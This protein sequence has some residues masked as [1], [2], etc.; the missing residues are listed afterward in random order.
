MIRA[1]D[2]TQHYGVRPILRDV[3]LEI[4]DGTRTAVI[5]PNGMG[6]TTLLGVLGGVL[7][8]QRGYVEIDGLRRR[9]SVENELE[10]RSTACRSSL[11]RSSCGCW[12]LPPGSSR[13]G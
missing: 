3:T 8:P 4:P 5:G 9:S 10:I 11:A 7:T 12:P 1:V 2:V 6:K 13:G